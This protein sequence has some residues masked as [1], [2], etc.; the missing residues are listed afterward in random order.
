MAREIGGNAELDIHY[1]NYFG[2]IRGSDRMRS[3][4]GIDLVRLHLDLTKEQGEIAVDE[5][6]KRTTAT[7]IAAAFQADAWAG[8]AE[9]KLGEVTPTI[10]AAIV[11]SAGG[12][13]RSVSNCIE[14]YFGESRFHSYAGGGNFLP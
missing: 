10:T 7:K 4:F 13:T 9:V 3:T 14:R 5:D 1:W 6:I 8:A 12:M 11:E 2:H